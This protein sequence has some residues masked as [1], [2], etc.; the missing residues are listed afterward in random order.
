MSHPN[1]RLTVPV[2]LFVFW[3]CHKRGRETRLEKAQSNTSVDTEGDDESLS[4]LEKGPGLEESQALASADQQ[5]LDLKALPA[6]DDTDIEKNVDALM[7]QLAKPVEGQE[8][9]H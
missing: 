4:D 8:S 5:S 3:Y 6:A 1:L 7:E 9:K 2:L